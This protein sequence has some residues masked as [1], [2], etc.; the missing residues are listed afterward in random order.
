[1]DK[2]RVDW[3]LKVATE[4]QE[5]AQDE[6]TRW[7]CIRQLQQAYAG[8]RPCIPSAVRKEDGELTR[9]PTE[10][11]QRW[12]QHFSRLLDQQGRFDEEVILQV[13]V[14]APCS[15]FDEPPSLEELMTVLS[16]LRKRKAGGKT[17]ILPELLLCGGPVLHDRLLQLMQD[18]W[19]DDEV[20]ADWKNAVVVPVPKKG[21][22]Q[23]CDN[24]R[25]IS[26]L[27]VVGKLF[28]RIVQDRLQRIADHILPESQCSFRKGRGCCDM[29]F[30]VRQLF[31][32]AREHQESLFTLFVDLRKAYDSVPRDALWHV[33]GR[34]GVP[35]QMLRIVRSFH[36]DIQ[37]EVRVGGVLSD[38]FRVRSGLHQ[39]CTLAPTLFIIY[40]IGGKFRWAKLSR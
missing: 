16:K 28:A 26:L 33:L 10:V 9:G 25:G 20:V 22:L 23:C 7:E 15:D 2:A 12:H 19:R 11:L 31:E 36:E 35:P 34:C 37:A 30:V 3:I 32:K 38:T 40:R 17:G 5:A 13:P 14:V 21:D 8:R 6:K 18:V 29:I 39:G 1:M 27:D 4:A 24:W